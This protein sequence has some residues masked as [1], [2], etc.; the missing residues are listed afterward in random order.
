MH[1]KGQWVGWRVVVLLGAGWL[2]TS[3]PCWAADLPGCRQM[4]LE[5]EVVAGQGYFQPL[6]NGL[7][8]YLQPIASGWIVRVVPAVG[9]RGDVDYAELATPPYRSVTPLS[10][11]TDFAFRAQDAVGWNPRRFRFAADRASFDRLESA[12]RQLPP[13]GSDVPAAAARVLAAES[14][15]GLSA[16]LRI[17]DA[18]LVPG[19]ANQW[20]GAAAV[21]SHFASTA[22]TLVPVPDAQATALGSLRWIRFRVRVDLSPEFRPA[23]GAKV[24][25]GA[26]IVR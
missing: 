20:Q 24:L 14:V 9:P 23:V 21:A 8:L 11:S 6:G 26:C 13:A 1:G 18:R 4:V 25:E 2:G 17:L 3:V 5:G 12:Y 19:T 16:E 7:A 10:I 22:H 15:R